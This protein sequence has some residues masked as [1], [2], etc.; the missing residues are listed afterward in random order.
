MPADI[1]GESESDGEGESDI[2]PGKYT[3][4]NKNKNTKEK[5]HRN[6]QSMTAKNE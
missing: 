4:I 5:L 2:P 6:L 1:W 3:S